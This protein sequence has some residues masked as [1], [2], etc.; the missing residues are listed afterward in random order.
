VSAFDE[1]AIIEVATSIPL[2]F[3]KMQVNI[4]ALKSFYTTAE[5]LCDSKQEFKT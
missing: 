1:E 4:K 5:R 3:R 2:Y